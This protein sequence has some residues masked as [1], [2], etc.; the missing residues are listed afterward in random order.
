M[1]YNNLLSIPIL[2]VASILFED[3]SG[4]NMAHNLYTLCWGG[5][6]CSPADTRDRLLFA[7]L[8]SGFSAVFISYCTAW[9]LRVTSSTTYRFAPPFAG[10]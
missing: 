10:C 4:M 5:F 6:N 8:I 2:V 7:I 3:W 9:C 1:F